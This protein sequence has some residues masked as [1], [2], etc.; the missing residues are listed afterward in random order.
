[1]SPDRLAS[2]PPDIRRTSSSV[3][4][5]T[6]SLQHYLN[7]SLTILNHIHHHGQVPGIREEHQVRS[8]PP[9]QSP[10]GSVYG[11]VPPQV[12]NVNSY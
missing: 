1:M 4:I 12:V 8:L 3:A 6:Q 11:L 7:F 10:D 2:W 5:H 9:A